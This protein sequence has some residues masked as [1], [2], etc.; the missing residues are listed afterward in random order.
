MSK[1]GY[2]PKVMRLWGP[3]VITPLVRGCWFSLATP[4]EYKG[5]VKVGDKP[6]APRFES[7]LVL[8]Q[9]NDA[10]EKFLMECQ[11]IAEEMLEEFNDYMRKARKSTLGEVYAMQDGNN[12]DLEKYPYYKDKWIIQ[13]RMNQDTPIVCLGP[14]GKKID[15]KHFVG[16]VIVKAALQ[17]HLG[18][19]GLSYRMP[20]IKLVKDDGVRFGGGMRDISGLINKLAEDNEG[21][22]EAILQMVQEEQEA[23]AYA[24]SN[25][26]EEVQEYEQNDTPQEEQQQQQ[27]EEVPSER[28]PMQRP[29]L[30]RP[31][32]TPAAPQIQ[33]RQAAPQAQTLA[34]QPAP[35]IESNIPLK[36]ARTISVPAPK[37]ENVDA[38]RDA[39]R[40]LSEKRKALADANMR[41]GVAAPKGRAGASTL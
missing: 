39:V 34:R 38:K 6:S 17:L 8:D 16:G 33:T 28:Q 36:P 15:A 24:Q 29:P 35:K 37:S 19:T 18:T 4:K 26:A 7:T 20:T 2:T 10:H 30:K 41:K 32:M 40:A 9:G 21:V 11:E 5:P 12:F 3:E 23:D 25:G 27:Q 13:G 14:D 31:P 1:F 22:D